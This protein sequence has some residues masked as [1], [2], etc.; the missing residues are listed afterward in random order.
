MTTRIDAYADSLQAIVAAEDPSGI[1]GDELY[2][3]ARE[4]EKS[5]ELRRTLSDATIPAGNRQQV[6]EKLLNGKVQPVTLGVVSLLV[7]SNRASDLP[8]I[9]DAMVAKAAAGAS[10][11]L[12]EVRT[13]VPL[14]AAQQKKLATA[15]QKAYG[16]PVDVK[17]VVDPSVVGGVVAQ[18]GDTVIDGSL[19]SRLTKLRDVF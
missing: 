8:K 19:R 1:A 6:V 10:K 2:R 16:Q 13:A 3:V 4:F 11:A 12:A 14:S 17:V 9:V 18:I 7:A 15:L 5:D